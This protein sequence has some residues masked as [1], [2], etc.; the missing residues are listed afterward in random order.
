M[1]IQANQTGGLVLYA[2]TAAIMIIVILHFT[3]RDN[4]SLIP[5]LVV[6]PIIFVAILFFYRI[7]IEADEKEVRFS[8][9]IGWLKKS[10]PIENIESCKVVKNKWW[11]GWGIRYFPGGILYNVS[12]LQAIELKFKDR[13]S[14]VRLGTNRPEELCRFIEKRIKS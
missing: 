14:V 6:L 1:K 9:G 10:Y 3:V 13:K 11:Y 5:V 4:N 8:M 7:V 2:L 12:G